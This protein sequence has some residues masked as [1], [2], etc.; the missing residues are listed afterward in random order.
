[1]EWFTVRERQLQLRRAQALPQVVDVHGVL[2]ELLFERADLLVDGLLGTRRSTGRCRG[3]CRPTRA[4]E[5]SAFA[6]SRSHT[7]RGVI[8]PGGGQLPLALGFFVFLALVFL[9]QHAVLG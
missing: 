1:M 6:A 5:L 9:E 4:V 7:G 2:F 3:R 8:L